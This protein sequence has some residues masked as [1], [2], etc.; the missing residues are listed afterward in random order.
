MSEKIKKSIACLM[1]LSI[2]LVAETYA[3]IFKHVDKDGRVTYTNKV[4]RGANQLQVNPS[5][6][7]SNRSTKTESNKNYPG[8]N[9]NTQ[10]SRD[11][12]RRQ[13]LE[14]EL[15][16]EKELLN[17]AKQR[18]INASKIASI[19][20][21]TINYSQPDIMLYT[22]E[23]KNTKVIHERNIMALRKELAN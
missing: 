13:I 10:V 19:S 12:K 21:T 18:L 8:V 4:I 17:K 9:E 7:R 3:E 5:L 11:I 16:I 20:E 22:K 1:F 14:N 23:I 2:L 6:P 15:A